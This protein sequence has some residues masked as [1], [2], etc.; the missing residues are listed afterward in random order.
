MISNIAAYKMDVDH[1]NI[2]QNFKLTRTRWIDDIVFSG[3]MKD[4]QKAKYYIDKSIQK[5]GFIINT[6]KMKLRRRDQI[7]QAVGLNLNKH[8]PY[9]P[10][11]IIDHIKF[12][13]IFT[14]KYGTAITSEVFSEEFKGKDLQ[15]SLVG[16]IKF[17]SEFNLADAKYLNDLMR[18]VNWTY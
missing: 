14:S 7:P 12:V 6:R 2:C 10:Q 15:K 17:V 4:L 9:V 13:I 11:K 8:N 3:R 5:N 16:K 1:G 18:S